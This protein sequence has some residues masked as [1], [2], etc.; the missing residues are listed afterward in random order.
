[1]FEL[2][3]EEEQDF[4]WKAVGNIEGGRENLG[5]EMPVMIYRL[6]QYSVKDVLRKKYGKEEAAN[7]FRMAGELTGTELANNELD[8]SLPFGEFV[9]GLQKYMEDIKMGVLRIEKYDEE[10]GHAVIT[11]GEDLDC[12][13]MPITGDTVC[14]YDEGL[15]AGILK[16][17]TKRNYNVKEIDCWAT[18]ARVCR[19]EAKVTES[20]AAM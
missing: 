20:D 14:N 2:F 12:S 16:C 19:F 15:L 6:F 9:A 8:L 17:Y 3:D 4:S 13:A 1:M 10:T 5:T 11:I 7:I 18:G